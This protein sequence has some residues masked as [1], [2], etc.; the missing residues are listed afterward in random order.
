MVANT[1]VIEHALHVALIKLASGP[2]N[3][4]NQFFRE[5]ESGCEETTHI[6]QI[7]TQ[8]TLMAK[9]RCGGSLK[10]QLLLKH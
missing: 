3:L 5:V 6:K 8:S 2:K 4:G 9:R 7:Q 10:Q 1:K